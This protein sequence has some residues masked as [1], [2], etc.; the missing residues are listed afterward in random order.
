LLI[1]PEPGTCGCPALS[2]L[3][4]RWAVL[5]PDDT[6]QPDIVLPAGTA[7]TRVYLND[8]GELQAH[9]GNPKL[10]ILRNCHRWGTACWAVVCIPAGVHLPLP[11]PRNPFKEVGRER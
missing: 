10:N 8:P 1:T 2:D 5:K 6:W 11:T 4:R 3:S 9:G 7:G